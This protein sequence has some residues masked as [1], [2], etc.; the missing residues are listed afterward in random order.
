VVMCFGRIIL[1]GFLGGYGVPSI[2]G[3][4]CILFRPYLVSCGGDDV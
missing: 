1:R 4:I 3:S 2:C